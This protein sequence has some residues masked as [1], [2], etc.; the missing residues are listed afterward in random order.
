MRARLILILPLLF[1]VAAMSQTNPAVNPDS[2]T[3][4][5]DG[6]AHVTRVVPMPSTVSPEAQRW[7]KE[8]EHEA[9]QPKDLAE[10]RARTGQGKSNDVLRR[11][12]EQGT[13]A[14]ERAPFDDAIQA[15]GARLGFAG[16]D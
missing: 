9:P 10:L 1:A 3:F 2:A 4:D 14:L 11:K 15:V 8:I 16:S 5:P 6:T 12:M 7:L 13:L